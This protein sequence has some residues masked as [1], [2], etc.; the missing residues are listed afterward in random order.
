M[1]HLALFYLLFLIQENS[2]EYINKSG[3]NKIIGEGKMT[4]RLPC[5]GAFQG[6]LLPPH[7]N[8]LTQKPLFPNARFLKQFFINSFILFL[9]SLFDDLNVI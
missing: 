6:N 4:Y 7:A 5:I 2:Q 1:I 8:I 3:Q 9:I